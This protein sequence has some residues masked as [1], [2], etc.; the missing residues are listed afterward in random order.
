MS[1]TF[2]NFTKCYKPTSKTL[3]FTLIPQGKTQEQINRTG[4]LNQDIS[5]AQNY[6]AVKEVLDN[7]HKQF[8]EDC[9]S[10]IQFDWQPLFN[11]YENYRITKEESRLD[12]ER[13]KYIKAL[14]KYLLEQAKKVELEPAKIIKNI[15][16]QK[17]KVSETEFK[18]IEQFDKFATYFSGYK[19]NRE[20]IYGEKQNSVAYRVVVDNFSKFY[21]N[22]R[23]YQTLTDE[24][25]QKLKIETEKL[26]NGISLDELF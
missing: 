12:I 18:A 6:I 22:C 8:I 23:K 26:L 14:S 24:F 11:A 19:E 7:V 21:S 10:K 2:S 20:N 15:L 13:E 16:K 1:Q 9:L 17:I 25:K 4:I 5:R 3:R